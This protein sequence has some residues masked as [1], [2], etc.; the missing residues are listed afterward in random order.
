M[1]LGYK[2]YFVRERSTLTLQFHMKEVCIDFKILQLWQKFIESM[3]H[4]NLHLFSTVFLWLILCSMIVFYKAETIITWKSRD[5]L[6]LLS[7]S[8]RDVTK[9]EK[10][11]PRTKNELKKKKKKK[12]YYHLIDCFNWVVL[13]WKKYVT[14]WF[15]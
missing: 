11:R 6:L 8:I 7:L 13:Y 12:S 5:N 2:Q 14:N 9:Y 15:V 1:I 4:L 3:H 10:L